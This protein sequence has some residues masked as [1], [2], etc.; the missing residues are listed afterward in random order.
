MT[1]AQRNLPDPVAAVGNPQ[2]GST[3]AGHLAVLK[4]LERAT[5]VEGNS[6]TWVT[7]EMETPHRYAGLFATLARDATGRTV[8]IHEASKAD[9]YRMG[10]LLVKRIDE[11]PGNADAWARYTEGW[12]AA[13]VLIKHGKPEAAGATTAAPRRLLPPA[14]PRQSVLQALD[15]VALHLG[16]SKLSLV[17]AMGRTLANLRP[18]D[19]PRLLGMMSHEAHARAMKPAGGA[20]GGQ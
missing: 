1:S 4:L 16:R 11:R 13:Y 20:G 7:A 17:Q 12:R 5:I 19:E 8:R 18:D 2:F 6:P 14:A 10:V 9:L 15:Y 3:I